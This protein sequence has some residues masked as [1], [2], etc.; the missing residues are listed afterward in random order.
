MKLEKDR[1]LAGLKFG[2]EFRKMMYI[3]INIYYNFWSDLLTAA[4][5][6]KDCYAKQFLYL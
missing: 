3:L 4:G 6:V 1:N 2:G 5:A